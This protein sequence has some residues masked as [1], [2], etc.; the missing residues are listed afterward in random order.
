M[1]AGHYGAGF[2]A[3]RFAPRMS[4]GTMV[5]AAL[6]A[7]LL[8]WTLVVT[9]FEHFAIKPGITTTNPLD[10]YDYPIS[11]SLATDV[12]WGVLLAAGYYLVRKYWRGSVVILVLVLSHWFLDLIAHRPDMPLAPGIHQY[13]GLG[14]YNSR[15]GMLAIEGLIWVSGIVIYLRATRSRNRLGTYVFWIG[16]ALLTWVWLISLRGLPPPGTIVQ[17]GISSLLFMAV[18][19]AWAYWVDHLRVSTASTSNIA[20]RAQQ[21]D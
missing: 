20:T 13:Y 16:A 1:F 3:K 8:G 21:A 14:L 5:L 17:A 7:D 4:L 19:V 11:H 15:P 6:L 9:G 12:V 10:L 18:T 2:A